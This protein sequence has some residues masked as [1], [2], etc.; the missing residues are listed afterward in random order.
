M[1]ENQPTLTEA[2]PVAKVL[3]FY[4]GGTMGMKQT[5]EG[6]QASSDLYHRLYN[7]SQFHDVTQTEH[8]PYLT[9]PISR[10]GKRIR[11]RIIESEPLLDSAN[12][13]MYHWTMMAKSVKQYYDNFDAFIFIHGTDTMAYSASALS[14]M[15]EN[16]TKTVIFTGSQ[17]PLGY[18][19]TDA[20]DN[21]LG[22]LTIAGHY[23]LP[24]VCLYFSQKLMRGNRTTKVDALG[25]E[26]FKSPNFPPLVKIGINITV[27]WPLIRTL[28]TNQDLIVR[29]TLN[30]NVCVLKLFPVI[31][32]AIVRNL[33]QS[34]LEG[35]VLETYGAG[36]GPQDNL[37]LLKAFKDAV[38]RGVVIVNCTQCLIGMVSLDY[39]TGLALKK[40]GVVTGS[41]MTTEAALAKL[42]YLLAQNLSTED[43]KK[44]I[45][46]DLRGE[47]SLKVPIPSGVARFSKQNS[48]LAFSPVQPQQQYLGGC[49]YITFLLCAAAQLG[50]ITD[51]KSLIQQGANIN[52]SDYY[53]RT[54]LHLAALEGHLEVA[55]LLIGLGANLDLKDKWGSTPLE[56]ANS[57]SRL[58]VVNY[59]KSVQIT[60]K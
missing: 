47:L 16:L 52:A 3:I 41:D 8:Y 14:F 40:A 43:V 22:A 55:K 24:E 27:N 13:S 54:P 10:Y 32:E 33:L 34:P 23:D 53:N 19:P 60:K 42:C 30:P 49:K 38:D 35:C 6:L 18:Y 9:L 21:L 44:L 31:T 25:F 11:Y 57:N 36:N 28:S 37:G 2:V 15:L 12:I 29:S 59:L 58:D 26:A 50:N 39:A 1:S 17:L 45:T 56:L 20:I 48:F 5:E 4:T 46:E 51:I 7:M